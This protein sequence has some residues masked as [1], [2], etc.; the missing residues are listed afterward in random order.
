[1]EQRTIYVSLC[2]VWGRMNIKPRWKYLGVNMQGMLRVEDSGEDLWDAPFS[3][4]MLKVIVWYKY[5]YLRSWILLPPLAIGVDKKY[6]INIEYRKILELVNDQLLWMWQITSSWLS[7]TSSAQ[8]ITFISA[9]IVLLN[10]SEAEQR[11]STGSSRS[12]DK[13]QKPSMHCF[14]FIFC[15]YSLSLWWCVSSVKEAYHRNVQ[16]IW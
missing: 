7:I 13:H 16:H 1:M 8:P 11:R 12:P 10:V 4:N 3:I 9:H 14:Y 15:L 2:C 5:F 6:H